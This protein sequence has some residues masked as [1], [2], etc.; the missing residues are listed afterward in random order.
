MSKK[1]KSTIF[2]AAREGIITDVNAF[3]LQPDFNI[4]ATDINFLI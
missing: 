2:S 3:L 4:N 1:V